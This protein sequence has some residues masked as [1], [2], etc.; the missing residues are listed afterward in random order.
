M[1]V[2][3][4]VESTLLSMLKHKTVTQIY[5]AKIIEEVGICKGTFYKYYCDKYDLLEKCFNKTYYRNASSA[6]SLDEFLAVCL[7]AFRRTP[8]VV[9]HAM[10]ESDPD[11]IF[12]YHSRLLYGY[13]AQDVGIAPA[14]AEA[15]IEY[16]MHFY[17]DSITRMT[18]EWL[19]SSAPVPPEKLIECIHD[20]KPSILSGAGA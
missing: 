2:E 18:A 19:A 1:K 4:F 3:A 14:G 5:V 9:L 8:K 20:M 15:R 12:S 10:P 13:I 7:P 11:S 6:G 16:A 17:A